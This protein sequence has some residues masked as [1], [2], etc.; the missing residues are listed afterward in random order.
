MSPLQHN[1]LLPQAKVF[2]DYQ[3]SFLITLSAVAEWQGDRQ[4]A[5]GF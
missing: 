2:G 4:V 3:L 1:Q 5:T